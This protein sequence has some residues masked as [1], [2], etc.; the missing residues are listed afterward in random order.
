MYYNTS[1][2]N[3]IGRGAPTYYGKN[4]A[5]GSYVDPVTGEVQGKGNPQSEEQK[6]RQKAME[7]G[8]QALAIGVVGFFGIFAYIQIHERFIKGKKKKK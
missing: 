6:K 8:I 5:F 3:A 1:Y 2:T 4:P 7:Q